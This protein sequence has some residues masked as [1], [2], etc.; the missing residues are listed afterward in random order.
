VDT[1]LSARR[2]K[3]AVHEAM[4]GRSVETTLLAAL[5]K[6]LKKLLKY[7]QVFVTSYFGLTLTYRTGIISYPHNIRSLTQK[8][9]EPGHSAVQEVDS[10]HS[11]V[12]R[13]LKVKDVFSL[14]GLVRVL[15]QVNVKQLL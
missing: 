11:Q 12:E 13:K 15:K 6:Y 3:V 7:I 4:S 8:F 1:A 10:I 2:R 14:V 5:S 9:R